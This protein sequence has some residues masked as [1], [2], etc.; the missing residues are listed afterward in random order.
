M[1]VVKSALVVT[2]FQRGNDKLYSYMSQF[3]PICES[4]WQAPTGRG[5]QFFKAS[6]TDG[7]CA[8]F[9][10]KHPD[11]LALIAQKYDYKF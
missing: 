2:A 9:S 6:I 5:C 10:S 4:L 11:L 8:K 3:R 7:N 1:C